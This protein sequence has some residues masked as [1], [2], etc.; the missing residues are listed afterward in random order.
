METPMNGRQHDGREL[1]LV[2]T[3]ILTLPLPARFP[4]QGQGCLLISL[5]H[6]LQKRELRDGENEYVHAQRVQLEGPRRVKVDEMAL[7]RVPTYLTL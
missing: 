3:P 1:R 2:S 4:L 5:S 6:S 7:N